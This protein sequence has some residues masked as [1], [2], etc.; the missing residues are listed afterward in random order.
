MSLEIGNQVYESYMKAF[1]Q[2]SVY[3]TK[4]KT[5]ALANGYILTDLITGRRIYF[6]DYKR[7]LELKARL[8]P[9][10]WE[11]YKALDK[12]PHLRSILREMQQLKGEMERAALNYPIQSASASITKLACIFIFKEIEAREAY[13]KILFPNVIHDQVILEVPEDEQETWSKIVKDCMERA[14][15]PFCKLVKLKAEPE[16]LKQWKK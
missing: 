2:L 13:F 1:P 16:I 4:Q 7:Y 9:E 5:R 8:T 11:E 6:K 10:F 12:P 14:G 15:E 3:F